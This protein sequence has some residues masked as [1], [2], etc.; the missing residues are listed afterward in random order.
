M[1][2]SKRLT[3][4]C[5]AALVSCA[6]CSSGGSADSVFNPAAF[7]QVMVAIVIPALQLLDPFS[8]SPLA[9]AREAAFAPPAAPGGGACP[10]DLTPFYCPGGGD[11]CRTPTGT[12]STLVFTNCITA[13]NA[14]LDGTWIVDGTETD[15]T[16]TLD[17]VVTIFLLGNATL[18]GT[19]VTTDAGSGC[20]LETIQTLDVALSSTSIV[21][22]NS[23]L[24][25]CPAADWPTGTRQASIVD[26]TGDFLYLMTLSAPNQAATEVRD[27][28]SG[29]VLAN[30]VTNLDTGVSNCTTV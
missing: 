28:S 21:I 12:G 2:A 17:L 1:A 9:V 25:Y 26:P 30:C 4:I 11:A 22:E 29:T 6:G 16:A 27:L 5:L 3:A 18:Q 8:G 23:P 20:L 19:I 15:N 10:E 13:Q 14:T 24:T 7:D